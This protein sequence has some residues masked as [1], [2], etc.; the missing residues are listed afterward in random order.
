MNETAAECRSEAGQQSLPA[1]VRSLQPHP[2]RSEADAATQPHDVA[3]SREVERARIRGGGARIRL[4]RQLWAD[5]VFCLKSPHEVST[6]PLVFVAD[7]FK[8]VGI[9]QEQL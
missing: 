8:Q 1:L 5:A 3:V 9:R 7:V 6:V 2:T 4:V